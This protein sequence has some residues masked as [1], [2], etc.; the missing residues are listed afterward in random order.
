MGEIA[1]PELQQLLFSVNPMAFLLDAYRQILLY[2]QAP[3]WQHLSA[4]AAASLVVLFFMHLTY[5]KLNKRI[6]MRV[7]A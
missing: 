4:I 7:L 5:L 1:D 3:D 2:Q 6:A